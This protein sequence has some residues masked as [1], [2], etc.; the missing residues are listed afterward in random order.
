MKPDPLSV[1][2]TTGEGAGLLAEALHRFPGVYR[3]GGID[4]DETD[5]LLAIEYQGV[6][7]NNSFNGAVLSA[8]WSTKQEENANK[9]SRTQ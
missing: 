9:G 4:A 3:L 6:A 5:L 8:G 7:V 2:G 1:C